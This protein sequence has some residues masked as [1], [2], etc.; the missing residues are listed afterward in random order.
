ANASAGLAFT[1]THIAAASGVI[2]WLLVERWHRGH[3]SAL[4][5]ASGLVAGLVGITPAAGFVPPWTAIIIGF[6]AGCLCYGAIV[7]KGR[8]GYD[9]SLDVVGVHGVGGTWG[10]LATGVFAM[11][12][13]GGASGLIEGNVSQ[14]ITQVIGVLA[15]GGYAAVV[16]LILVVVLNATMGF[17]VGDEEE[18]IGLDQSEHGE[19]GYNL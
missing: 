9:D 4:G 7:M 14:F 3:A 10:A 13:F 19:V 11:A 18:Q 2:G 5:A 12:A 15:A 17:R 1:T 6:G 8:L 16:T